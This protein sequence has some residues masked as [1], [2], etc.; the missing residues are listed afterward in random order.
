MGLS[1]DSTTSI[2]SLSSPSLPPSLHIQSPHS[3]ILP[4]LTFVLT[5]SLPFHLIC[6]V[7]CPLFHLFLR[8][9]FLS[10]FRHCVPL[11]LNYNSI[12]YLSPSIFAGLSSLT[13]LSIPLS[14]SLSSSLSR[15]ALNNNHLT[16][17]PSGIF[18][19]LHSLSSLFISSSFHPHKPSH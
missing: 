19:D 15:F 9:R 7:I 18:S 3:F 17:L 12:Y 6:L 1:M 13:S 4:P 11:V 10:L 2:F 14:S 5:L 8:F 16:T